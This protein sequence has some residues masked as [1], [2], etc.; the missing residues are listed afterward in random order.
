MSA[1]EKYKPQNTSHQSGEQCGNWKQSVMTT[2]E[3][4]TFKPNIEKWNTMT[5]HCFAYHK[6]SECSRFNS[7]YLHLPITLEDVY[8]QYWLNKA[9][10]NVSHPQPEINLEVLR[11]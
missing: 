2:F 6:S 8:T 11:F 1:Y 10:L 4:S 5:V 3:N 9:C 7:K